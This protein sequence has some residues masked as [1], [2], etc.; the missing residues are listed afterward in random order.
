MK[1]LRKWQRTWT[2]LV[3]WLTLGSAGAA[4]LPQLDPVPGGVTLITLPAGDGRPEASFKHRPVMVLEQ[5][6]QW[7]ALLGI[8]LA[9]KAGTHHLRIVDAR[10]KVSH[11]P[12]E[13]K[14]YQY[15]T[16]HITI[17]DKRKVSPNR[18]DLERIGKERVRIQAALAAFSAQ[19]PS[20]LQF[21]LPVEGR[22]SSPF[23]LR[24]F[25]N[26]QPRKPHSGLDIAAPEGTPIYAPAAE[27]AW[28]S[29]VH[30]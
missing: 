7:R 14:D 1:Q 13:V 2:L 21:I 9:T 22:E 27:T 18:Q 29:R 17:K 6:G 3:L 26:K 19:A 20:A 8:P 10:G 4:P 15:E 25:F 11:V 24:R 28:G 23:G 5:E 30:R 16:Q 12:F